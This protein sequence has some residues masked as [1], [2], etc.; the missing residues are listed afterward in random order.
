[1]HHVVVD[2]LALVLIELLFLAIIDAEEVVSEGRCHE[3]LLHHAVHV[4]DAAQV[5][6][7]AVLLVL[8]GRLCSRRVVPALGLLDGLDEWH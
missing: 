8:G 3:E 7:A 6:E 5:S 1:M 4:A 2:L